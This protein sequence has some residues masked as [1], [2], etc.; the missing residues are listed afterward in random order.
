MRRFALILMLLL[1]IM[2]VARAAEALPLAARLDMQAA[3]E[4]YQS[5]E[6]DEASGAWSARGLIADQLLGMVEH[7]AVSGHMEGGVCVLYPGV[8]GN[9]ELS[10]MEPVLY[11]SLLRNSPIGA[12]ALSIATGGM[13]YDFV[14]KAEKTKVGNFP[15][16]QFA[17]PLGRQGMELLKRFAEGGG[18]VRIYGEQRTFRTSIREAERYKNAKQRT[19]ALSA[20]AVRDFLPQWPVEYALWDLN[21]A[22]WNKDRPKSSAVTLD[23]R[24]Y[25]EGL[26]ELEPATQCVDTAKGEQVGK[27]QQLLKDRAFFTDKKTKVFNTA[28]RK[29]TKRAQQYYGL[30]PT[31]MPDKALVELLNGGEIAAPDAAAVPAGIAHAAG[32]GLSVRLDRVWLSRSV[33]PSRDADSLDRLWPDDRSNQLLAADGEVVNAS[34][35][36]IQLSAA[37]QAFVRTRDGASCPCT[38]QAERDEGAGFGT[39]LLP[40]GASRLVV[41]CETPKGI[42]LANCT[43]NIGIEGTDGTVEVRLA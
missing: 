13:R 16:E 3:F 32:G 20:A 4:R 26:P 22:F 37:L 36:A 42:D 14:G 30:L 5:Y 31:G 7:N 27:Y 21:E 1:T 40:G 18:E 12:D 33:A 24:A 6:L 2:P 41:L 29:A 25:A 15:C 38:V 17:L 39:S 11:V 9:R 10:L 23:E 35:Q 34:N 28:T 43:L 19:E 8:R